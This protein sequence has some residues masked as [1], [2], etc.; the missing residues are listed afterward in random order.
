MGA[1]MSESVEALWLDEFITNKGNYGTGVVIFETNKV[2]G[3]DSMYYYL[4]TF[5]AGGDSI[6]GEVNIGHNAGPIEYFWTIRRGK[7]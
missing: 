1:K 7:T 2:F 3:G 6:A 4:G 5:K